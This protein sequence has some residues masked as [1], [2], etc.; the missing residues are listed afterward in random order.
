VPRKLFFLGDAAPAV[1][2]ARGD[3]RA[4]CVLP[5]GDDIPDGNATRALKVVRLSDWRSEIALLY[6]GC[7]HHSITRSL[8][9]AVRLYALQPIREA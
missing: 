9:E 5:R 7:P 3:V 2:A 6:A 1:S 4:L 8:R